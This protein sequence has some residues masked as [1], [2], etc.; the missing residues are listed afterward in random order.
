MNNVRKSKVVGEIN[1]LLK[2]I[3]SVRLRRAYPLNTSIIVKAEDAQ[4]FD[5]WT[6]FLNNAHTLAHIMHKDY[7]EG[8][9]RMKLHRPSDKKSL[10]IM[11]DDELLLVVCLKVFGK[12]LVI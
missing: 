11:G 9:Y 3:K 6:I 4:E 10:K 5:G 2:F 12:Y 1:P 8:Y 7:S